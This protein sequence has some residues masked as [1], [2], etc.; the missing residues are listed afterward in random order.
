[1]RRKVIYE[2]TEKGKDLIPALL[3]L[4]RWG[5]KHDAK[6]GAPLQFIRRIEKDREGFI[7][8]LKLLSKGEGP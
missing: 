8:E 3:E 2:L 1:M 7:A 6:T 4:V 5:A